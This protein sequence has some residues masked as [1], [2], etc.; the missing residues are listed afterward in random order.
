MTGTKIGVW[1]VCGFL[2]VPFFL[3]RKDSTK[4]LF[5]KESP[6]VAPILTT[7][8]TSFTQS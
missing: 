5:Y 3:L 1:A 7:S 6:L 4:V 8:F 2:I